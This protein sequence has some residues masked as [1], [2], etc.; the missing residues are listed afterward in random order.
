MNAKVLLYE[1]KRSNFSTEEVL[2]QK[3]Y[4]NQDVF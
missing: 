1:K 3:N 4:T 2:K